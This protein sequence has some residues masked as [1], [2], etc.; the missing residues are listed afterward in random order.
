MSNPVKHLNRIIREHSK[1][2]SD[3]I[4]KDLG[5][6]LIQWKEKWIKELN[7]DQV[8]D[9]YEAMY[10]DDDVLYDRTKYCIKKE[11]GDAVANMTDISQVEYKRA[12][13]YRYL[14]GKVYLLSDKKVGRDGSERP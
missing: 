3:P 7:C 1:Y 13:G 11:I 5:Y 12:N 10:L 2:T 6:Q 14:R 9:P 8:I 4:I